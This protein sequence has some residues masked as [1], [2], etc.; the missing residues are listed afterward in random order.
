MFGNYVLEN[1]RGAPIYSICSNCYSRNYRR[2]MCSFWRRTLPE[3]VGKCESEN[4]CNYHFS[5][6]DYYKLLPFDAGEY[7]EKSF[8]KN[9]KNNLY[10]YLKNSY[11]EAKAN[12]AMNMYIV[13]TCSDNKYPGGTVFWYKDRNDKIREGRTIMIDKDTGEGKG[14]NYV[15]STLR[16]EMFSSESYLFGEHLLNQFP[17]KTIVIVEDEITAIKASCEYSDYIWV[18][19]PYSRKINNIEMF[20]LG[21]RKVIYEPKTWRN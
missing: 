20:G 12:L 17:E 18:S 15:S 10:L 11:G 7:V 1:Y 9:Y 13:G 5:A 16:M 6:D 21:E 3:H 8:S 14:R 2:Y 19:A 4:G